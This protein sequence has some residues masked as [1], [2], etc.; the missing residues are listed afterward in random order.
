MGIF[1]LLRRKDKRPS[2]KKGKG[3]T[4]PHTSTQISDANKDAAVKR[5]SFSPAAPVTTDSSSQLG[6][7]L[8]AGNHQGRT[9]I[10]HTTRTRRRT[11]NNDTSTE[12]HVVRFSPSTSSGDGKGF[13]LQDQDYEPT[14]ER[15]PQLIHD[16]E[17][18]IKTSSDKPTRALRNLFTLSE[19]GPSSNSNRTDMVHLHD[20][21][22]V[23]ALFD[24]LLRCNRGSSEQYLTLLVLNNISIPSANKRVRDVSICSV[25]LSRPP[26]GERKFER[27]RERERER[28]RERALF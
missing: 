23:P 14:L 13:F 21:T 3:Q 9:G 2:N 27:E 16:L 11:H 7:D 4:S 10:I 15:L 19:N 1:G 24:F 18:S 20:Q 26:L 8:P 17:S 22:L 25:F 6:A 28:V 5:S 12:E